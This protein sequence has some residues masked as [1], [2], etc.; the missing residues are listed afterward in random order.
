[1]RVKMN[2]QLED[3]I[4]LEKL[5]VHLVCESFDASHPS[6]KLESCP[7]FRGTGKTS[8]WF[9]EAIRQQPTLRCNGRVTA[10]GGMPTDNSTTMYGPFPHFSYGQT[11]ARSCISQLAVALTAASLCASNFPSTYVY[12]IV[13]GLG[14]I[15]CLPSMCKVLGSIPSACACAR[16]CTQFSSSQCGYEPAIISGT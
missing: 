12:L 2:L 9:G 6:L 16:V 3:K 7:R 10:L 4:K 15:Q 13:V 8:V 14:V 1:M 11:V 5:C